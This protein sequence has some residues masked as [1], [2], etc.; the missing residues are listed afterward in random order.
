MAKARRR[1]IIAGCIIGIPVLLFG[2]YITIALGLAPPLV[3]GLRL[4]GG[5]V[6]SVLT[7]TFGPID[8][9]A[10]VFELADGSAGLVDAGMDPDATEIKSA[11]SRMGKTSDDV[12]AI[13]ITHRHNDHVAG[14]AGFPQAVVYVLEPDLEAV[15]RRPTAPRTTRGL[16]DG[17]RLD[18]YGTT[19]EVYAL[20]GHTAGSA[21]FLIHGVLFLGDSAQAIRGGILGPN[22]MLSEDSEATVRSMRALAE[23]LRPRQSEISHI[24]FAHSG[25][26]EGLGPLLD[27]ASSSSM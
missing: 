24:A 3:G 25:P 23:R 7:G 9:G 15:R 20:P 21:A 11:L 5:A 19:V 18:L 27:W 16:H 8:I 14:A 22:T 17:E 1:L 4:G 6:T 26:L 10:Y 2:L 12:K 13:L